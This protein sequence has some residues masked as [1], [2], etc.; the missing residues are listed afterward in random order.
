MQKEM[1]KTGV[2]KS[3]LTTKIE[4]LDLFNDTSDKELKKL[5]Q[6]KQVKRLVLETVEFIS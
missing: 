1:E 2:E 4:E 6:K 3:S 5:N